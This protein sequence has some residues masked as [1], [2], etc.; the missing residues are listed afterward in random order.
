VWWNLPQ[1]GLLEEISLIDYVGFFDVT[2][3]RE[4]ISTQVLREFMASDSVRE[5]ISIWAG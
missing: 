4:N 1:V 3:N 5:N 2:P